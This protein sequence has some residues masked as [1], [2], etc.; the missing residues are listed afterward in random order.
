MP[1][2]VRRST[3]PRHHRL[4][5]DIGEVCSVVHTFS[6][7]QALWRPGRHRSRAVALTMMGEQRDQNDE[8]E[9]HAE[10]QQQDR[11]HGKSPLPNQPLHKDDV[12]S[13]PTPN[14]GGETRA[15]RPHQQRQGYPQQ[16]TR[17]RFTGGICSV[18]SPRKHIRH[19]FLGIGW[20][21]SRSCRD[22]RGEIALVCRRQIS[23]AQRVRE[24]ASDLAEHRSTVRV[25][26]HTLRTEQRIDKIPT[27]IELPPV[28]LDTRG[29]PACSR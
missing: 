26:L 15:K 24:D 12:I 16:C 9:G 6:S 2:M 19:P 11:P 7:A 4:A 22:E 23:L 13:L 29:A 21:E 14:G 27:G 18:L 5:L 28:G 3:F 1:R 10:E 8:R 20:A 25:W 17:D